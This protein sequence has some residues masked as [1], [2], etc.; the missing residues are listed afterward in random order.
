MERFTKIFQI[1]NLRT[2]YE[3]ADGEAS[4]IAWTAL[5]VF[6]LA[7][8]LSRKSRVYWLMRYL[9]YLCAVAC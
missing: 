1:D 2:T 4:V 6:P 3:A 5:A 9:R 8:E 7:R